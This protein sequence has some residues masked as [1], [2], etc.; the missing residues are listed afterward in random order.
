V[1]LSSVILIAVLLVA[2]GIWLR[3]HRKAAAERKFASTD[4]FVQW[5]ASEAVKDAREQN[6]VNLDY[7]IDSIKSVEQILGGLH[8]QYVKDPSTISVK[9]LGS[10]YGAYIGE[11]IR[12]SEPSARWERDD[13]LGE[14]TY[15]IIWGSG[16]SYPMAWCIRRILNGPEDNVWMKYRVLKDRLARPGASPSAN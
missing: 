16:H 6:H 15:P 7:S 1:K 11:V 3:T 9:G 4:E 2:S 14:K 10:A 13:K 12:R 8:D 5:L